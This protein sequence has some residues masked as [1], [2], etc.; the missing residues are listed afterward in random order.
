MIQIVD[1][2]KDPEGFKKMLEEQKRKNA[3]EAIKKQKNQSKPKYIKI[4]EKK[5]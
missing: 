2:S 3:L 5:K 1:W 4:L